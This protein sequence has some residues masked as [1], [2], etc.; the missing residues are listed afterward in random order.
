MLRRLCVAKDLSALRHTSKLGVFAL[1]YSAG[2]IVWRAADGSYRAGGRYFAATA[3]SAAPYN[4]FRLTPA[5]LAMGNT[6]GSPTSSRLSCAY[7]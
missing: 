3:M 7:T 4:L 2:F 5:A 6:R 1:A